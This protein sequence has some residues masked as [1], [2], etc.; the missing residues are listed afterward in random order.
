MSNPPPRRHAQITLKVDSEEQMDAIA[1]EARRAGLAVCAIEVRRGGR[2]RR[3]PKI[4]GPGHHTTAPHVKLCTH[5]PPSPA[6]P[7]PQD[8]G[9]TEVEPG[10]RTVLGI[11]PAPKADI[12]KIT[13]PK[14]K[15]PL[16]L[17][18]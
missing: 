11:G 15:Y 9:R 8:A 4:T 3:T 12:D 6:A 18:A 13:G 17:L 7:A 16:R 10:T 14:G 2:P 5:P 1:A